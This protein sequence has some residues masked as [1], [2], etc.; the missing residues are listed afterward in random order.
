M[1]AA[2][3][4]YRQA[5]KNT[6]PDFDTNPPTL[7][8]SVY[9]QKAPKNNELNGLVQAQ[10][11]ANDPNSFFDPTTGA[12]VTRGSQPNTLPF[13]TNGT[14]D[15]DNISDMTADFTKVLVSGNQFR[16]VSRDMSHGP[17]GT[18]DGDQSD[19]D[20]KKHK[21]HKHRAN[22]GGSNKDWH[23][24]NGGM[25]SGNRTHGGDPKN[26]G[27]TNNST[28]TPHPNGGD[29][30]PTNGTQPDGGGDTNNSTYTPPPP[31]GGDNGPTNNTTSSNGTIRYSALYG[32]NFGDFGSCSVPEIQ[33]AAGFDGRRETSFEPVDK[34]KPSNF[35]TYFIF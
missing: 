19:E 31:N 2:A 32:G 21:P 28:S 13:G 30:G 26:G 24:V 15:F 17:N 27:N 14:D 9:C 8:N 35:P 25:D 7:R 34:G 12:T 10:D 11:P 16:I 23:V 22:M 4:K 6:P 3:V 29:N 5:E 20:D 18:T 33:F 1:I